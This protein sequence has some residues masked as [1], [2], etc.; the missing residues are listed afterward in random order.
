MVN[1]PLPF[2]KDA[3]NKSCVDS[4]PAVLGHLQPG[5]EFLLFVCMSHWCR[6]IEFN[7][8]PLSRRHHVPVCCFVMH[9]CVIWKGKPH[10]H[11]ESQKA[12][13]LYWGFSVGIFW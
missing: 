7:V 3:S 5:C 6:T 2:V 12:P 13:V 9:G 10:P 1:P 8:Y 4:C 11:G